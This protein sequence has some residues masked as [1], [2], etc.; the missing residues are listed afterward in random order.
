LIAETPVGIA[1]AAKDNRRT[2]VIAFGHI[3][4]GISG[5][6]SPYIVIASTDFRVERS[7]STGTGW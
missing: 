2:T 6:I 7:D 3:F 4:M 1:L 5:A